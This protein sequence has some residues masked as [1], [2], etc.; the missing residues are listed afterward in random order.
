MKKY[1]VILTVL[2]I[3]LI[4]VAAVL[5]SGVLDIRS[6]P[7]LDPNSGNNAG[8]TVYTD[9]YAKSE[10]VKL[11]LICELPPVISWL[12]LGAL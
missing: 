3:V 1:K 5:V 4:A 12:T 9:T 2:L 6:T 10:T 8:S 7:S 11:P